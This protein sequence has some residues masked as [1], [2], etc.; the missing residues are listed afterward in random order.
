MDLLKGWDQNELASDPVLQ[1][2]SNKTKAEFC[3]ARIVAE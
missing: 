3:K 1:K 2:R